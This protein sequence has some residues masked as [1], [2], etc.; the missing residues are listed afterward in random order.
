MGRGEN[1]KDD[2][3]RAQIRKGKGPKKR[4]KK[5]KMEPRAAGELDI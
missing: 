4:G 3:V 1:H 2:E 5:K